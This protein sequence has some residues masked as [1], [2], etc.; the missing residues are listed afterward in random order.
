MISCGNCGG[1]HE[2]SEQT[3]LCHQ[4]KA[5][6]T[7]SASAPQPY[8]PD[9]DRIVTGTCRKLT[10]KATKTGPLRELAGWA[11]PEHAITEEKIDALVEEFHVGEKAL[12]HDRRF[13]IL[14]VIEGHQ[15]RLRTG[16][17][18]KVVEITELQHV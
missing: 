12:W 8:T 17:A 14:E 4:G 6:P 11:C 18:G 9:P 15:V 1:R 5:Q 3:R 16:G 7:V 2:T 13:E 10:C